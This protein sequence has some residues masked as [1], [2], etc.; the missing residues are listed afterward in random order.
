MDALLCPT[1]QSGM[2]V[3][4]AAHVNDAWFA[5]VTPVTRRLASEGLTCVKAHALIGR[6]RLLARSTVAVG[7]GLK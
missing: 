5:S 6:S 2:D 1:R 4:Q 3:I 7:S